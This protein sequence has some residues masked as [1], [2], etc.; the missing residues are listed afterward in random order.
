MFLQ[1]LC[2]CRLGD[3]ASVRKPCAERGRTVTPATAVRPLRG[4]S[5]KQTDLH[6]RP[7][8]WRPRPF[9]RHNNWSGL[10][11]V[12][13][14]LGLN[15]KGEMRPIKVDILWEP[16]FLA[17]DNCCDWR[18]EPTLTGL[19]SVTPL[20]PSL[21]RITVITTKISPERSLAL[22][23]TRPLTS[24]FLRSLSFPLPSP[25]SHDCLLLLFLV[26]S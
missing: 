12:H 21:L 16:R 20:Y 7:S 24:L 13:V 8:E 4:A 19:C 5:A 9:T 23:F 10:L 14:L 22:V 18:C 1:M 25:R 17:G 6:I 3:N 15:N 26:P 11:T 2:L